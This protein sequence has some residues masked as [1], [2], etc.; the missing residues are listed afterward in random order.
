MSMGAKMFYAIFRSATIYSVPRTPY[1]S[2]KITQMT[3]PNPPLTPS[4]Q[5][6]EVLSVSTPVARF[7]IDGSV[8]VYAMEG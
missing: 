5:P 4:Q 1:K 6:R 8:R 3:T 7:G 2:E